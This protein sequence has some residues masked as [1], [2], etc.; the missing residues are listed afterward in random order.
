MFALANRLL[1][2]KSPYL[3]QHAHNP[4]DW[5]PWGT[6]AFAQ[7]K[8]EDK[9]IFLSIGYSSCHW[10][11]KMREESFSDPEVAAALN[12]A[13]VCIKV[14][15]EERPDIDT[16]YMN[17][18]QALTGSGGWPLT[19]LMTA[20]KQP[21]Y[22]GTY[23]P[24]S[25]RY[26]RPGL[27]QLAKAVQ[28]AWQD[29]RAQLLARATQVMEHLQTSMSSASAAEPLDMTALHVAYQHLA[30]TFDSEKGGFGQAPKFPTPHNLSFLLRYWLRTGED[31]AL[32]MVTATLEQMRR[33]GI[34]DQIGFGF[35]R[36]ATDRNWLVP[37]F[38]KMLYDQALLAIAYTEAW[39]VTGQEIFAQTAQEIFTYVLRDMQAPEGGFYTAEDADSEGEEGKF[40]LWTTAE[41][42]QVLTPPDAQ[43]AK[44]ILGL[45]EAGNWQEEATGRRMGNN[46]LH[47]PR[48]LNELT[49]LAGLDAEQLQQWLGAIREILYKVR[50]QRTPPFKDR[51]ILADMNGLMLAALAI[52]G[53][54]FAIEDYIEA[55]VNAADLIY[56]RLRQPDGRLYKRYQQG[57]VG[58][59]AHLDDYAFVVWGLIELYEATG[60]PPYLRQALEL[61]Q[62]MLQH[63]WDEKN[64][65]FYLT[66]NDAAELPVRPKEIY[67]GAIPSGNSVAAL[68]NLRLGRLTG[69]PRLEEYAQHLLN[70][71]AAAIRR[72]PAGHCFALQ[73]L[74]FALGPVQE[75]VIVGDFYAP[76]MT[77]M[78]HSVQSRFLPRKV[79]VHCPAQP[80]QQ[81][82]LA[83]LVPYV[84]G[85]Q[86]LN[87]RATA[88][89]CSNYA[90]QKPTDSSDEM[91]ALLGADASQT[92]K[93][94]I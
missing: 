77:H 78:L 48:T 72:Y 29:Q 61:N 14:D 23:F 38:E 85:Y 32:H 53:R 26:G 5:Y 90:C 9:P 8:A 40:Y 94:S 44:Q 33:G 51:K 83:N 3:Q 57:E 80:E 30:Q 65:G 18:C 12:A 1:N 88:Y 36:Y 28:T 4:V 63:Y 87:N 45:T 27:L 47:L 24:K 15:R 82:I 46:I 17:V 11:H 50:A 59:F 58:V 62:T 41:L 68:N 31:K 89:V 81:D 34:F 93:R 73:A 79:L 39:Q 69:Q 67:D 71:F 60:Q 54:V 13:F 75:V 43:L 10:C 91:L 19:V 56:Y 22:A 35:H 16:V 37:H 6:E 84:K 74:D 20:D 55:A 86:Q 70:S 2:E 52:G 42:E 64:G 92:K 76:D 66:A 7:A 49:P 21:F 25:S